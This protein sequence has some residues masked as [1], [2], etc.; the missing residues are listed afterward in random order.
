MQRKGF[1]KIAGDSF[2]YLIIF[3]A[4]VPIMNA[5]VQEGLN[6]SVDDPLLRLFLVIMIP[7][8]LVLGLKKTVEAAQEPTFN[9]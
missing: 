6:A 5:I 4:L 7:A 3:A 8:F 2:F 1:V 9:R